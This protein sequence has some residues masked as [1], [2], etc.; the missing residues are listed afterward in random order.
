MTMKD[1]AT[2]LVWIVYVIGCIATFGKLMFF[3]G[4][5]YNWW[6]WIIAFAINDFLAMFW[7][8]Y[9]GLLRWI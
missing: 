8:L 4:H 2:G 1:L 7:P 5:V 3:D 9:W 6:N